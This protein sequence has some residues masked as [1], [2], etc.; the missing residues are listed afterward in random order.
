MAV[1][2]DSKKEGIIEELKSLLKEQQ[3]E[4]DQAKKIIN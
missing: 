2:S 3:N 1:A 4:M